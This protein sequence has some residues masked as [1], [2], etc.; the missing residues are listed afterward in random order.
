MVVVQRSRIARQLTVEGGVQ[1][2]D[3][4]GTKWVM[5][6][7]VVLSIP[8]FPLL[9]IKVSLPV[10]IVLLSILGALHVQPFQ[11]GRVGIRS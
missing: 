3:K 7:G 8:M 10:F 9:I 1:L 4:Y 11:C 5:L 2:S 6:G